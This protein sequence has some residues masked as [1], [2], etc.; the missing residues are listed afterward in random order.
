M[1]V[2]VRRLKATGL[3]NIEVGVKLGIS[4]ALSH[5]YSQPDDNENLCPRCCRKFAPV[6]K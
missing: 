4:R 2:E 5:Y 6:T 1:R 3:T